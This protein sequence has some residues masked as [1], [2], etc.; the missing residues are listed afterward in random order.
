MRLILQ[1]IQGAET[2]LLEASHHVLD[3]INFSVFLLTRYIN[4]TFF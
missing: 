1:T 2:D 4:A 3:T